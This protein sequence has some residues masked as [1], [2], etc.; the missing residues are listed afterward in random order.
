MSKTDFEL[1]EQ[2]FFYLQLFHK[3]HNL[4]LP[5]VALV[6]PDKDHMYFARGA[7]YKSLAMSTWQKEN[8]PTMHDGYATINGVTFNLMHE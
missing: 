5:T 2:A 6:Y 7:M 3:K 8:Q 4:K 1:L